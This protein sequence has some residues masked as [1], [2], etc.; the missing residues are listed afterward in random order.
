MEN[1]YIGVYLGKYDCKHKKTDTSYK[2]R[3]ATISYCKYKLLSY[4]CI[5]EK[6]NIININR[7]YYKVLQVLRKL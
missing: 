2:I 6:D 4:I 1:L 5:N 3:F 7:S